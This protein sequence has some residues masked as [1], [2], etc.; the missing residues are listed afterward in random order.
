MIDEFGRDCGDVR[1]G[2]LLGGS[3]SSARWGFHAEGLV[4]ILGFGSALATAL[5]K[6]YHASPYQGIEPRTTRHRVKT[7]NY[8]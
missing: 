7:M 1:V 8:L 6:K 5:Y 2:R 4:Q 3:R